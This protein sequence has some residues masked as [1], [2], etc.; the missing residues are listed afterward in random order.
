MSIMAVQVPYTN[1]V[2]NS[3][4]PFM[5][6][7]APRFKLVGAGLRVRYVG[8]ELNRGGRIV[9]YTCPLGED[10]YSLSFDELASYPGAM[11]YSVDRSWKQIAYKPASPADNDYK[12]VSNSYSW[13][14]SIMAFAVKSTASNEFEYEVVTFY[15]F[16]SNPAVNKVVESMTP[17]SSDIVG[18]SAVQ[19]Y[20]TTNWNS[21]GND[22]YRKGL[23]FVADMA[24]Q[25][26]GFLKLEHYGL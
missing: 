18:L 19:E 4:V 3:A 21:V 11:V 24:L 7:A 9:G 2:T 12:T 22:T 23:R 25:S 13:V 14:Q 8:T 20:V 26:Q 16:I 10:L 5:T 1:E 6:T 15:E 17:T